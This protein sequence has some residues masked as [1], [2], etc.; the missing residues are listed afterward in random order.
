MNLT[1]L[2][3]ALTIGLITL[4]IGTIIFN[5]TINRKNKYIEKP[6]GLHISFFA[7]GFLI[8]II[9]ELISSTQ[10]ESYL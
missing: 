9:S 7:T 5:L 1:I 8:Y 4:I 6:F 2:I 3:E 10:I